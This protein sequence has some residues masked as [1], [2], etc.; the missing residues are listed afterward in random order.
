M[1]TVIWEIIDP[2]PVLL[3]RIIE[4]GDA[5]DYPCPFEGRDIAWDIFEA[6]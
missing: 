4:V 5:V 6:V 2:S 1:I 3:F